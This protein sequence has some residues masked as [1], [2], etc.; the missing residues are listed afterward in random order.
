[1]V[2]PLKKSMSGYGG[3]APKGIPG[4]SMGD[5]GKKGSTPAKVMKGVRTAGAMYKTPSIGALRG[6]NA[7][8]MSSG[9]S[10]PVKGSQRDKSKYT[11]SKQPIQFSNEAV[12]KGTKFVC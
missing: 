8:D 7:K 4:V 9:Q 6:K 2:S 11:Q 1:M 10:V 12:T 3:V 5:G